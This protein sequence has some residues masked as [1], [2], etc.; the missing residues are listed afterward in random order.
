MT[1]CAFSTA[2]MK[3]GTI[4]LDEQMSG[5][6][7]WLGRGS[8]VFE[9]AFLTRINAGAVWKIDFLFGKFGEGVHAKEIECGKS[10]VLTVLEL[11]GTA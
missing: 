6:H 3:A 1:R 10:K 8:D 5:T 9:A 2:R 11:R 4:R 7:V